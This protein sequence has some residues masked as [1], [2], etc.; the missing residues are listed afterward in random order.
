[1][2]RQLEMFEDIRVLLPFDTHAK[3]VYLISQ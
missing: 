1:M 2:F 3:F